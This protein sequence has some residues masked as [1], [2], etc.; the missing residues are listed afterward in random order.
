MDFAFH[1]GSEQVLQV[2]KGPERVWRVAKAGFS[3]NLQRVTVESFWLQLQSPLLRFLRP[4]LGV[5]ALESEHAADTCILAY[6]RTY[7]QLPLSYISVK[8]HAYTY[9]YKHVLNFYVTYL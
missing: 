6:I 4:L 1:A 8:I 9:V 5:V 3:E 7:M 2:F